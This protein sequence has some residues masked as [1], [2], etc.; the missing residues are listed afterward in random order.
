MSNCLNGTCADRVTSSTQH[1]APA[2]MLVA[3]LCLLADVGLATVEAGVD[4]QPPVRP[5]AA[6]HRAGLRA[7][8][9]PL[10]HLVLDQ[11]A[12][13]V[14]VQHPVA[15]GHCHAELQVID[16]WAPPG[17]VPETK[18]VVVP[19]FRTHQDEDGSAGKKAP[20]RND[21]LLSVSMVSTS[22]AA[23]DSDEEEIC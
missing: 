3:M 1:G 12:P 13:R 23:I 15:L 6:G 8:H 21:C 22:V 11:V 10:G 7:A 2:V 20:F 16:S 17:V 18:T 5:V 19:G 14:D 9:A 4:D